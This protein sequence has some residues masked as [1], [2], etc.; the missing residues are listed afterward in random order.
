[1]R[2]A[3]VLN[4]DAITE[5]A[6]DSE[7]WAAW[8]AKHADVFLSVNHEANSPIVADLGRRYFAGALSHR[9]Q[10]RLRHGY[11]EEIFRFEIRPPEHRPPAKRASTLSKI[12]MSLRSIHERFL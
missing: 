12:A 7:V 10:Y 5:M 8:I 9:F 4:V 1:M 2:F 11:I 6:G 3:L